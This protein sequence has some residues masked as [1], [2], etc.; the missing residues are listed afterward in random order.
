MKLSH[1]TILT[2]ALGFSSQVMAADWTDYLKGMQDSCDISDISQAKSDIPKNLQSSIIKYTTKNSIHYGD[3]ATVDIRLKNATAFGQ[4]IHRIKFDSGDD[5]VFLSVYFSNTDF[6]K[7][8][9]QFVLKNASNQ[10]FRVGKREAWLVGLESEPFVKTTYRGRDFDDYF[11]KQY[12]LKEANPNYDVIFYTYE[13]GWGFLGA[14]YGSGI[15]F[16]DK[17]RSVTCDYYWG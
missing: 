7:V 5:T 16:N 17:K 11:D 10:T 13:N 3:D 6:K 14:A 12:R 2:I 9:P 1:L 15:E 8:K 4:P